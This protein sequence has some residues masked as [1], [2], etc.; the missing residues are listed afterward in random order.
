MDINRH[1]WEIFAS[2][3]DLAAAGLPRVSGHGMCNLSGWRII[4]R[5]PLATLFNDCGGSCEI[6]LESAAPMLGFLAMADIVGALSKAAQMDQHIAI[7]YM[8]CSKALW[9]NFKH[10][11][12]IQEPLR[13]Q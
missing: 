8:Y 7:F 13:N 4:D 10:S 5:R 6:D 9:G 1:G 11:V 2:A 12:T 3:G